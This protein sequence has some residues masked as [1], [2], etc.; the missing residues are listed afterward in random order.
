M[1]V[2][3]EPEAPVRGEVT[4]RVRYPETD[5]MGVA[6]HGHYLAW[7][8]LGRTE[9]M[10]DLGCAYGALEDERGVHFP[11]IAV[12]ARYHAPARYDDRVRIETRL[13]GVGRARVRFE[14]VARR[15]HD[16]ARLA[17]GFSEHASVDRDGRPL[18]LPHDVSR[19]LLG[20]AGGSERGDD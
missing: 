4:T 15:E 11:V 8:E 18:R 16:G 19:T 12:G 5:R 1:A 14:Y 2:A 7:F 20:G 9:L 6:W 17:T 3:A 13:T 10:R